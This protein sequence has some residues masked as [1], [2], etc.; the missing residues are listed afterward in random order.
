MY[1][2]NY[3]KIILMVFPKKIIIQGIWAILGC[4][5]SRSALTIYLK[6]CTMKGAKKYMKIILVVFQKFF[7]EANGPFWV[8]K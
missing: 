1:Y 7:V 4:H 8:Q 6:F 3:I 2:I 5:N